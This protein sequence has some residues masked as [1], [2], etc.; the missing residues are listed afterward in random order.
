MSPAQ[1]I[2]QIN[3]MTSLSLKMVI[4]LITVT[5]L[6]VSTYSAM[7][8]KQ[9]EVL[10]RLERIEEALHKGFKC[11]LWARDLKYENPDLV[12]PDPKAYVESN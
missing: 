1:V 10:N 8:Y 12:I 9:L 11:E 6:I 7:Y 2:Q 5:A 3:D 4:A